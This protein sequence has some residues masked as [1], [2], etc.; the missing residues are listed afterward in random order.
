MN[1]LQGK[2]AIVTGAYQGIGKAISLAFAEEG[3]SV[4]LVDQQPTSV[5]EGLVKQVRSLG[6]RALALQADI[7]R[8]PEVIRFVEAV[9]SEFGRIDILVNNAGVTSV[10]PFE[11]LPEEAWDRV[12]GVNLKGVFLCCQEVGHHMIG[13]KSGNIINMSSVLGMVVLPGRGAY[14]ASK[15][16]VSALTKVLAVEWAKHSVRV[17]A[18]APVTTK[19]EFMEKLIAQGAFSPDDQ[20][21][22]IPAGRLAEPKDIAATAVFLA[23][24]ESSLITGQTLVIDGGYSAV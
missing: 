21:K 6:V 15:A 18:I 9:H 4:I 24:E 17:N 12:I 20:I 8:K 10:G 3:A 2:I 13:N 23:S 7:T 19:T 1:R 22:A 5:A 14:C 11:T 16:A